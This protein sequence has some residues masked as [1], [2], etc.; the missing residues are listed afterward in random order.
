VI[1][2]L[3]VF[4]FMAEQTAGQTEKPGLVGQFI[5]AGASPGIKYQF[6]RLDLLR[7]SAGLSLLPL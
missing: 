5:D 1:L 7:S 4:D 6:W 2:W 3:H